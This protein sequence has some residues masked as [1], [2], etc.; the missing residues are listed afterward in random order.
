MQPTPE[1]LLAL[2]DRLTDRLT[3]LE[4]KSRRRRR[5]KKTASRRYATRPPTPLQAA[6]IKEVMFHQGNLSAAAAELGIT[7]QSLH[8]RF[9]AGARKFAAAG[10]DVTGLLANRRGPRP[11]DAQSI[12]RDDRGQET[13]SR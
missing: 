13:L 2:I 9:T 6:A 3:A 12:P 5:R 10:V 8:E 11:C 4:A 1:N 7:K